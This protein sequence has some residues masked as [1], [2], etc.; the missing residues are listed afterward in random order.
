MCLFYGD[1]DILV[2]IEKTKSLIVDSNPMMKDKL[3]FE[4]CK[5]YEHMDTLW[6]D[7]VYEDVFKKVLLELDSLDSAKIEI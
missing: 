2:D 4:L 3:K 5:N 7:D 1:S 6:G